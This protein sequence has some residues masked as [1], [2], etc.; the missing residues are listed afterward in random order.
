MPPGPKATLQLLQ[1]LAFDV[2]QRSLR[3]TEQRAY[4]DAELAVVVPRLLQNQEAMVAWFDE[5]IFYFLLLDNF[6]PT[7]AT[8]EQVPTRLQKGELTARDAIGE[9]LLSTGFTQRNPGNDTFVTVV[10]EQCLG[11]QVQ[12]SKVKPV[13]AAGKQIYDGKKGRFLGVDG[14]N[15]ADLLRIVLGHVDFARHLLD[16]HHQR[17]FGA[18]L[19]KDDAV[20]A[21]VH[22]DWKQFFPV[23]G[24]WLQSEAYVTLAQKKRPKT[25]RQFLRGLFQDLLERTPDHDELRNLRNAL[26]SMADPTPLRAVLAKILLDSGKAKLPPCEPGSEDVF[27]RD[28]FHRYLARQPNDAE[29]AKFVAALQKDGANPGHIVRALVGCPEYQLY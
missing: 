15:Q 22:G 3:P 29:L 17:L 19:G 14:Q 26:Q 28:C 21:R 8:I 9:I 13:L 7:G 18:P 27:V 20:I 24:E 25:E 12:D 4:L 2:L 10:L 1:H 23:L 5:E 11:Y 6:R 16:R